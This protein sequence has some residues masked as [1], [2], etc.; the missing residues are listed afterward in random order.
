MQK[1]LAHAFKDLELQKYIYNYIL[2]PLPGQKQEQQET[3]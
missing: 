3:K 1:V 2:P